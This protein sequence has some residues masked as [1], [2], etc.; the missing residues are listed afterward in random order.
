MGNKHGKHVLGGRYLKDF[1]ETSGM[2]PSIVQQK[3]DDFVITNPNGKVSKKHFKMLMSEILPTIEDKMEKLGNHIFRVYD[4]N[5]DG[6]IDFIELMVVYHVMTGDSFENVLGSIF[7]LFDE[8]GDGTIS[9]KEMQRL[10]KD[11]Y[12]LLVANQNPDGWSLSSQLLQVDPQEVM[13]QLKSWDEI[14]MEV[15]KEMDKNGDKKISMEEFITACLADGGFAKLISNTVVNIFNDIYDEKKN[16]IV[17][18]ACDRMELG[19]CLSVG[20]KLCRLIFLIK[21]P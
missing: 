4:L 1:A 2:D 10:I 7:R 6:Y 17:D 19:Q 15:F 16:N 11:L 12:Q 14:A 9:I 3:F 8:N 5:N 20:I 18:I 13:T 21:E